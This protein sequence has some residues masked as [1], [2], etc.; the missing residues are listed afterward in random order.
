M[1]SNKLNLIQA[2][3]LFFF[4]IYSPWHRAFADDHEMQPI[5]TLQLQGAAQ[6]ADPNQ[7]SSTSFP[8]TFYDSN[9]D[10]VNGVPTKEGLCYFPTSDCGVNTSGRAGSC[11]SA[12]AGA[13]STGDNF[14]FIAFAFVFIP[15][16]FIKKYLREVWAKHP[17]LKDTIGRDRTP[18]W[19]KSPFL[20]PLAWM[21]QFGIHSGERRLVHHVHGCY[22]SAVKILGY[23][24]SASI[25]RCHCLPTYSFGLL[26]I[27]IR[28]G[29][30]AWYGLGVQGVWDCLS[31]DQG[32]RLLLQDGTSVLGL[33][34]LDRTCYPGHD[35]SSNI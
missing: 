23:L 25:R 31:I 7:C 30:H 9:G 10:P 2:A 19:L 32:V 22:G 28:N 29:V 6:A 27:A 12:S 24:P 14:M 8:F 11:C 17:I 5:Q 3:A 15:I 21:W 33:H 16:F 20:K 4:L 18:G 34:V 26:F 1:R 13:T 35:S